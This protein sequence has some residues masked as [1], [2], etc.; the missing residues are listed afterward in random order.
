MQSPTPSVDRLIHAAASAV[1]TLEWTYFQL[2]MDGAFS[3][4]VDAGDQIERARTDLGGTVHDFTT[5]GDGRPVTATITI[6]QGRIFRYVFPPIAEDVGG[7]L[8]Y[9]ADLGPGSP[10]SPSRGMYSVWVDDRA[11]TVRATTLRD[12]SAGSI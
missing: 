1:D 8:L 5:Y 10:D 7:R 6:E 4:H 12:I 11:G 9:H 3:D 2:S